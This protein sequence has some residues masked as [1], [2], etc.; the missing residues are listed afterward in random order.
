MM[1]GILPSLRFSAAAVTGTGGL[2]HFGP[3]NL[4]R[5][6]VCGTEV[7]ADSPAFLPVVQDPL[8]NT[9]RGLGNMRQLFCGNC[10]V[11]FVVLA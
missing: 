3:A 9:T 7:P 2:Q 4:P 1:P 11:Q 10:G 6:P 8:D 5:C